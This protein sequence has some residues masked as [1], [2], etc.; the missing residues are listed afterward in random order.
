MPNGTV[1]HVEMKNYACAVSFLLPWIT[2]LWVGRYLRQ[3]YSPSREHPNRHLNSSGIEGALAVELL[4]VSVGIFGGVI[5]WL[6]TNSI[7]VAL[8][9]VA[10]L[11]PAFMQRAW[12]VY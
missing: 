1:Q 9:G 10:G 3:Q 2:S 7:W 11:F 5:G 6:L 8:A 12:S 4:W